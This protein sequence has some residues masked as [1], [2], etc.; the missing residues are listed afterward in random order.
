[1]THSSF[2]FQATTLSLTVSVLALLVACARSWLA[3]YRSGFRRP[4]LVLELWRLTIIGAVVV[5]L[6]QPETV[7]RFVPQ[8]RPTLAVLVDASR[9]MD[10]TDVRRG[11][12]QSVPPLSRRAAAEPL[13]APETWAEL[14]TRFDVVVT[15]FAGEEDGQATDI[16]QALQHAWRDHP[17][18][19]AVVL[20]SD[21]D[22]NR[23]LP[24]VQAATE[25]R[26]RQI[27][28][29]AV[30]LGSVTRLPDLELVSFDVPTFGVADKSVRIPLTIESLCRGITW[31]NWNC[32]GRM[33]RSFSINCRSLPWGE[34]PTPSSE[35]R[36]CRRLHATAGDSRASRGGRQR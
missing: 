11:A 36:R 14:S 1:M 10:T 28:V 17:A 15:P 23:G 4:I 26:N 20:A 12:L 32:M 31:P 30:P 19:R 9:S 29:F 35:A 22:W 6:N 25:L 18:L 3:W 34:L 5:M 2:G 21:G 16:H 8:Q 7:Q 13:L 33:E 27:P 24:P